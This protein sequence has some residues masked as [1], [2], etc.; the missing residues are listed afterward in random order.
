[1]KDVTAKAF[2]WT[3]EDEVGFITAHLRRFKGD[4]KALRAEAQ[5]YI[6]GLVNRKPFDGMDTTMIVRRVREAAE[7]MSK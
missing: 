1:M 7:R 6:K 5:S 4:E 3:N 2:T